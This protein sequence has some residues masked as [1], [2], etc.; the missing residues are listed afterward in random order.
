MEEEYKIETK[1]SFWHVILSNGAYSDYSESHLFF[2]A[3]NELEVW[4][5]LKRYHQDQITDKKELYM[6]LLMWA[7]KRF[8]PSFDGI[9]YSPEEDKTGYQTERLNEKKSAEE[10][11]W[12]WESAYGDAQD[13]EIKRLDV[14]EFLK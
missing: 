8:I 14:I 2:R 7:D 11:D 12:C 5:M 10:E 1:S 6:P 9:S 3:N 4:D 13:V